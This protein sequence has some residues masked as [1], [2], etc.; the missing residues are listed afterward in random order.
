MTCRLKL[1]IIHRKKRMCAATESRFK[2]LTPAS[3]I[4]ITYFK[5][6]ASYHDF[7]FSMEG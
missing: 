3:D 4:F 2:H 6:Y 1:T 5:A 7:F